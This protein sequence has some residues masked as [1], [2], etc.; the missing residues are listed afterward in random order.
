[1]TVT[2]V[3]NL[4]FEA[5]LGLCKDPSNER[6]I[7]YFED[8]TLPACQAYIQTLSQLTDARLRVCRVDVRMEP[9]LQLRFPSNEL[10]VT[11]FYSNGLSFGRKERFNSIHDIENWLKFM[12]GLC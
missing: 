10:P 5:A 12:N 2:E 9:E 4:D 11:Y 7:L 1:M 3:S 8:P 6:V